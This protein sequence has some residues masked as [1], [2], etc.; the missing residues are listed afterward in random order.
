M[1]ETRVVLRVEKQVTITQSVVVNVPSECVTL[2][3]TGQPVGIKDMF[4]NGQ[5]QE[6]ENELWQGYVM[7]H[8]PWVIEKEKN[9][10]LDC[11]VAAPTASDLKSRYAIQ[12]TVGDLL[13]L[14][15]KRGM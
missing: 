3:A 7:Y 6:C 9:D 13:T 15:Q 2:N 8:L 1:S 10:Y 14:D 12:L 4:I 11:K 5:G